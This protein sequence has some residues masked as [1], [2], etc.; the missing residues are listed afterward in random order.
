MLSHTGTLELAPVSFPVEEDVPKEA[1]KGWQIISNHLKRLFKAI[2]SNTMTIEQIKNIVNLLN[3]KKYKAAYQKIENAIALE[4]ENPHYLFLKGKFLQS[5]EKYD[6]A[7]QTYLFLLR[8][9]PENINLL[10]AVCN[11]ALQSGMFSVALASISKALKIEPENIDFY[12]IAMAIL[13]RMYKE[14]KN[15]LI[16]ADARTGKEHASFNRS[17]DVI[18]LCGGE[19]TR[20]GSHLGIQQKQL[21]S[22]EGEILL[23]RTLNQIKKYS[24]RKITVLIRS[25]DADAFKK[26]CPE[27]VRLEHVGNP[28]NDETPAWKYLSSEQYWNREGVTISLLGDVWFSDD[29]MER[30]FNEDAGDWLAFGR[31]TGSEYTGCPYEEI[32]AHK[33]TNVDKHSYSLRLLDE[34]YLA[35]LCYVHAS[36]WALSQ[37]MSNED[38]NLQSV[39]IN[40]VEINDFTEDF[41]FP[42]DYEK[43]ISNRRQ[44][45]R[46]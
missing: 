25:E 32:F 16:I 7:L 45:V 14:N 42:E 33:F 15:K 27:G 26:Y 17:V 23:N 1:G 40:F 44:Y 31:S 30:I 22:V 6:E 4:P 41:D 29:A 5:Q 19:A 36:G 12:K 9:K 13:Q 34:L 43:W 21:I 39:G 46:T 38:P 37:L 24:P 28:S 11:T 8:T 18:I 35:K 20:W 3:D 2:D 10:I